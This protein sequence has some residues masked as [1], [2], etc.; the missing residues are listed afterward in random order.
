MTF[1]Q[2]PPSEVQPT[3][4]EP[5]YKTS[6]VRTIRGME[7]RT[8]AKWEKDG[9]EFVSQNRIGPL[10]NE[11]TFRRPKKKLP[12]YLWPAIG[13]FVVL[14]VAGFIFAGVLEGDADSASSRKTPA[15]T[16]STP[17]FTPKPEHT[18]RVAPQRTAVPI[19]SRALSETN[20]AHFL[21]MGWEAKFSYGGTV[22]WIVDRITTA[23][24]DGSYTF[25]IG[26]TVKN[27]YGTDTHATIEGDVAGTDAAP[28]IT[29]SI[30][31]TN[32]GQ[33]VNYNG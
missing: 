15:A 14:I 27:Q 28:T 24:A 4:T 6:S 21:A 19:P 5:S 23:N 18:T 12:W 26:A 16:A 10:R 11:L 33:E 30:L 20:A 29:D 25:K 9:W 8:R 7:A 1:D 32:D 22:H 3:R 2:T 13:A 17:S 31:Y